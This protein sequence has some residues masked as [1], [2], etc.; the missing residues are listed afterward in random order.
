MYQTTYN[1]SQSL[2]GVGDDFGTLHILEV[3]WSLRQPS[4]NELNAMSLY[5]ERE[6]SRL[7]YYKVKLQLY[8]SWTKF[9]G[10]TVQSFILYYFLMDQLM[11]LLKQ[12]LSPIQDFYV[13]NLFKMYVR[14]NAFSGT[15]TI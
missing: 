1:H 2:L 5:F 15:K 8:Q 13:R 10:Y 11:I 12:R 6:S 3:P 4:P 9:Q 7:D 14:F